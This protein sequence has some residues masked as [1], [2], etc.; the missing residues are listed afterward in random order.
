MVC[1][2]MRGKPITTIQ[3]Q[4]KHIYAVFFCFYLVKIKQANKVYKAIP[5][6]GY[7]LMYQNGIFY[8]PSASKI[9]PQQEAGY[10]FYYYPYVAS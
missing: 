1:R 2:A 7:G 10:N 3:I 9:Y 6:C 8:P 5:T 4:A